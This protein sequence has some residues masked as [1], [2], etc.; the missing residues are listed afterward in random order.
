MTGALARR[1]V[2]L[3]A[4]LVP[5]ERRA[6][7]AEEWLAEIDAATASNP[8]TAHELRR[9]LGAPLDGL[10]LRGMAIRSA[11]GEWREGM[12]PDARQALRVFK[13]HP[14]HSVA[15]GACLGLGLTVVLG[16]FSVVSGLLFAPWPGIADRASLSAI[17]IQEQIGSR[18]SFFVS[19]SPEDFVR[20]SAHSGPLD[21]AAEGSLNLAARP[22]DE[23]VPVRVAFVSGNYFNVLGTRA[24]AGRLLRQDDDHRG[25]MVA[26][27]SHRFQSTHLSR[28][29]SGPL[30]VSGQQLSVVGVT[31][32]GFAGADGRS[33]LHDSFSPVDIWVPLSIA[34]AWTGVEPTAA[35][36]YVELVARLPR[37]MSNDVAEPLLQQ[38]FR[39]GD[40][41]TERPRTAHLQRFGYPRGATPAGMALFV[42]AMMAAPLVVLAIACANV[43]NLRLARAGARVRDLSIR[44]SLGATRA[45]LVRLL[46]L[47]SL[48]LAA[49]GTVAGSLGAWI[50]L[51]V[52]TA[53]AAFP[54][55]VDARVILFT[56]ALLFGTTV[57]AGMAPALVTTRRLMRAGLRQSS[58][59]AAPSHSRFRHTMVAAQVALSLALLVIAAL[60]TRSLQSNLDG[61]S[62]RAGQILVA[63]V[64]VTRLGDDG[65]AARRLAADI[66]ARVSADRRVKNV[67]YSDASIFGGQTHLILR[68]GEIEPSGRVD[69]QRITPEWFNV[70]GVELVAGRTLVDADVGGPAAVVDT[71]FAARLS[72]TRSPVGMTL[73]L[74]GSGI[75]PQMTM[76][77]YLSSVA[78]SKKERT[79][80]NTD[81]ALEIVGVVSDAIRR[82]GTKGGDP[83]IYLPLGSA[84]T[85]GRAFPT[86]FTLFF[87]TEEPD[88]FHRDLARTIAE[89]E[90]RAPRTRIGTVAQ[91]VSDERVGERR[92][93]VAL[94]AVG[95]VALALAAA[96]LYAAVVY[97]VSLRAREIGI[98]LAVGA[99]PWQV[100]VLVVRQAVR[101][102]GFG[103][104]AGWLIGVAV[105]QILRASLPGI[106]GF[107]PLAVLAASFILLVVAAVSALAPAS[108]AARIDPV[109][110]L[111]PE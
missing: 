70:M 43:T 48:V 54:L 108:R 90:P 73:R 63:D 37:G 69:A 40:A 106:A 38:A 81:L 23:A 19:L 61:D 4:W 65:A 111:R 2:R 86:R 107:D 99:R 109:R 46:V 95:L 66:V 10:V 33:A 89:L 91:L 12:A 29:G 96:G 83:R 74:R 80:A 88:A 85:A 26:V 77:E 8:S 68:P 82:P 13:T 17:H 24:E 3:S 98:R 6:A 56:T 110:V 58:R 45:Q 97:L 78:L 7:W 55:A 49:A 75:S 62:T 30:V 5:G 16:T 64:D 34:P 100:V 84:A 102:V 57:L 14:G 52:L 79:T 22:A 35:R 60:V 11:V 1:V 72:P 18:G 92:A 47:E 104:I 93:V 105:G 103:L 25:G 9:A 42:M 71:T 67:A 53:R 51:K 87:R 41:S 36:L 44:V 32:A 59:G 94:N 39:I 27:V 28:T 76:S 31:E 20:V 15:V 101:P 21:I 50:A